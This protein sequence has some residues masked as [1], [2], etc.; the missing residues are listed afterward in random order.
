M[1]SYNFKC[2][3]FTLHCF[4]K[5]I[6]V[7]N[8][9]WHGV[10]VQ[11]TIIML[12]WWSTPSSP[13]PPPWRAGPGWPGS[14]PWVYRHQ[15]RGHQL[16]GRGGRAASWGRA[17]GRGPAPPAPA[18]HSPQLKQATIN[19]WYRSINPIHTQGFQVEV[20]GGGTE[21]DQLESLVTVRGLVRGGGRHH[22]QEGR[23]KHSTV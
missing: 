20:R 8:I 11:F 2:L 7:Y 1:N 16:E 14:L 10:V 4:H 23:L 17:A 22:G 15:E 21:V 6:K 19:G 13:S 12:G 18:A 9:T 5:R 3:L